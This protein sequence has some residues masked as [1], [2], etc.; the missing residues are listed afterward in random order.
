MGVNSE[1]EKMPDNPHSITVPV[2]YCTGWSKSLCAPDDYDTI[3]YLAQ[4][5][6]LAADRQGQWDSTLTPTP[7]VIP[8]SNYVI[9]VSDWN[10]KIFLR[11]FVL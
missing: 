1:K 7:S 8:T 4:S 5:G 10:F 6:C 11:V 2:P 3:V 9:M